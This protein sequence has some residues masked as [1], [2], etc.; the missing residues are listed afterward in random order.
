MRMYVKIAEMYLA[1]G[2][3]AE[4]EK[5]VSRASMLQNQVR[6]SLCSALLKATRSGNR[7]TTAHAL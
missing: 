7:S 3:S 4:A 5:F 2:D 1:N 6:I